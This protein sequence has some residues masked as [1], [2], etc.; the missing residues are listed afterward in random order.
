MT[1]E[2]EAYRKFGK[3]VWDY[4]GEKCP[5]ILGSEIIGIDIM[6]LAQKAGLCKYAEYDPEIHGIPEEDDPYDWRNEVGIEKGD[7]FWEWVEFDQEEG[8]P[9]VEWI[10]RM[11]E[12]TAE[13][14]QGNGAHSPVAEAVA[15]I[16][17]ALDVMESRTKKGNQNSAS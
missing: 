10:W 5:E 11:R 4:I 1:T 13:A 3:A 14:P 8:N 9:N 12:T 16:Y 15:R 2:Q 7:K 6:D 17:D